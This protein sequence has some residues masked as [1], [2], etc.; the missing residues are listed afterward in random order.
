LLY[1]THVSGVGVLLLPGAAT[2]TLAT[3]AAA[4]IL[5]ELGELV[6]LEDAPVYTSNR[7]NTSRWS[8]PSRCHRLLR[9]RLLQ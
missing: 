9:I 3:L 4:F 8:N 7:S 1:S 5:E 6:S 2:P